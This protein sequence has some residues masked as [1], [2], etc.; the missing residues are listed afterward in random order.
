MLVTVAYLNYNSTSSGL[1]PNCL[2]T[3][4]ERVFTGFLSV[5]VLNSQLKSS[6]TES[7]NRSEYKKQRE[8]LSNETAVREQ[9]V[10]KR[11]QTFTLIRCLLFV[12]AIASIFRML[13]LNAG[14]RE[15]IALNSQ[16]SVP[17]VG[18]IF[19]LLLH[20]N[21]DAGVRS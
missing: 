9:W 14:I 17:T 18:G 4:G 15:T 10:N 20:V 16:Y 19:L 13:F 12:S 11:Y 5:F 3:K 8:L 6:L 1:D 21:L 7:P 2:P